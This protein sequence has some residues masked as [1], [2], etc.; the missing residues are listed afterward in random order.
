MTPAVL[1]GIPRASHLL[2]ASEWLQYATSEGG[3]HW[4]LKQVAIFAHL[5]YTQLFNWA[6]GLEQGLLAQAAVR[7]REGEGQEV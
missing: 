4:T 6:T 2:P 5:K 1:R 7:Q 3:N